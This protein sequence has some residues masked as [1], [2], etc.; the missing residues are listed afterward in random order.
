MFTNVSTAVAKAGP[1]IVHW[2]VLPLYACVHIGIGLASA[3]A[4]CAARRTWL[5]RRAA[6]GA[7]SSTKPTFSPLSLRD[8]VYDDDDDDDNL[9]SP[10][11]NAATDVEEAWRRAVEAKDTV[12][13]AARDERL[14]EAVISIAIASS[15]K[16][17]R[18][19]HRA[20]SAF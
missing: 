11:A 16:A 6:A 9:T 10:A 17:S 7:L 15:P 19:P 1:Q 14:I 13:D 4:L 18:V 3:R 5:R 2:L 12:A 20:Q 8:G